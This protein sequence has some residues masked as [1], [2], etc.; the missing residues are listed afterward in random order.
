MGLAR[1]ILPKLAR[2]AAQLATTRTFRA[3]SP[4]LAQPILDKE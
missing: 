1:R 4:H 3:I 2:I